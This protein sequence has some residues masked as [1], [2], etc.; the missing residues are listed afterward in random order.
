MTTNSEARQA[1]CRVTSG[2][3]HNVNGDWLAFF[4]SFGITTGTFNERMLEFCNQALGAT[5]DVAEWDEVLWDG[6]GAGGNYTN[7]NEAM[8]GFAKSN[9]I[10]GNG[11]LFSSLGTF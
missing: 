9:G 11:S 6:T 5:W 4:A 10:T 8:A 2:T 3:T 1:S 7:I